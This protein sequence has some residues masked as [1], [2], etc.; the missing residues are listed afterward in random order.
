MFSRIFRKKTKPCFSTEAILHLDKLLI[1]DNRFP[2]YNTKNSIL[3]EELPLHSTKKEI[4]QKKGKP[5]CYHWEKIGGLEVFIMGYYSRIRTLPGCSAYFIY[6]GK[7]CFCEY[8]S[9]QS[10]GTMVSIMRMAIANKYLNDKTIHDDGFYI[11]DP[12]EQ[13]LF[14]YDNGIKLTIKYIDPHCAFANNPKL[15]EQFK[16]PK[17]IDNI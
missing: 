9:H 15:I 3:F 2:V 12:S 16:N 17:I 10:E 13:L 14:F 4:I 8:R 5:H 6:N 1:P 7:S 11:E